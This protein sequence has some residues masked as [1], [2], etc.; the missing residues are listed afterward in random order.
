MDNENWNGFL[1]KLNLED[2]FN[3][4]LENYLKAIEYIS[5]I[6]VGT[7]DQEK[8]RIKINNNLGCIVAFIEKYK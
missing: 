4:D 2:S 5:A 7:I 1:D 3:A 6:S 8:E